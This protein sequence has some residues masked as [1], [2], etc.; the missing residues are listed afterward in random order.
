MENKNGVSVNVTSV[1]Q[2]GGTTIGMIAVQDSRASKK[3]SG[4]MK[5]LKVLAS[6]LS[7]IIFTIIP[8]LNPSNGNNITVSSTNQSGGI[9]AGII[10]QVVI[11][12]KESLGIREKDAV[13]RE[14]QK[15]GTIHDLAVDEDEASF[16][17]SRI[18]M[19]IVL[20]NENDIFSPFETGGHVLRATEVG[21]ATMI[22]PAGLSSVKGIVLGKTPQD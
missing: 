4:L 5:K 11:T 7:I 12:D 2:S 3:R 19:N 18:D 13:Y 10:G 17:A 8:M 9:T 14:N 21:S 1:G 20:R 15:I 6:I 16:T 22:Y